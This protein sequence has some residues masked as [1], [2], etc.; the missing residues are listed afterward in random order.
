MCMKYRKKANLR[1]IV[2]DDPWEHRILHEVIIGPASQCVEMHQVL[3]VA[4]LSFL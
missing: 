2:G 4:D 3:E 1:I